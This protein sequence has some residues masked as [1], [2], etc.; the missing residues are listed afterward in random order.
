MR[1][2]TRQLLRA[3]GV[4]LLVSL[5]LVSA[6]A[7]SA[8]SPLARAAGRSQLQRQISAGQS[9]ISDLKNAVGSASGRVSSLD[10]GIGGLE[11]QIVSTQ[12]DLDAQRI[13]LLTLRGQLSV[14]RARLTRLQALEKW[15]QGV[16]SGQLISTYETDR[17]DIVSVVLESTGF[18]D[19][20][21]RLYFAQRIQN[22]DVRIVGRVRAARRAVAAQATRLGALDLRQQDLT[23]QVLRERNSLDRNRFILL[24]RQIA[25]I[26]VRDAKAGQLAAASG[27]VSGLQRQ[28]AK[29]Q[30]AQAKAQAPAAGTQNAPS[31]SSSSGGSGGS[32]SSSAGSSQTSSSGGFAFPLPKADVSPPSTWSLDD[33]V[34]MSAPGGTPEYAVCSGAIV[35]HGIGGFGPSAPVL[36]C[37][38]PLDGY[39]YVYY[40]HAGPGN[41]T[42]VGTHVSAGQVI[43]EIGYGIVGI[44]TGPHV[45][46]GFADS[47][48]S[49]IGPSSASQ[50]MSLL[51]AAYGG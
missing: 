46:M 14:A 3:G 49:P 51:Q 42:P 31:G 4:A 9:R 18:N 5:A 20:L 22:Q 34:D 38:S 21:E 28:L 24:S 19:L 1:S 45:E 2:A 15:A 50:M 12:A 37:D 47:S 6:V 23:G 39:D 10:A 32:S 33:G 7:L 30:A 27:Q 35:L 44:S 43:S 41:W 48:G 13:E 17:P 29:I 36:H 26:R 25:A 16:L 8:R 11:R 40:G